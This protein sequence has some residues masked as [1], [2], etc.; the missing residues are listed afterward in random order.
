MKIFILCLLALIIIAAA[1]L[2]SRKIRVKIKTS[3]LVYIMKRYHVMVYSVLPGQMK[4]MELISSVYNETDI[5][6][7]RNEAYHIFMAVKKTAKIDGDIAEVGVYSGGSAKIISEAK[8]G[9][10][11]HLFD[12]FE[13]LPELSAH[14][15]KVMFHKNQLAASYES[16]KEY[17]KRY[18]N[19][20]MY[21]GMF[22]GTAEPLKSSKFSFVNLDAD[23]YQSTHDSLEFFYPRMNR[24]GIIISHDYPGSVGV[25]KAFDEFFQSKPEVVIEL[26]GN[27]CMVVK[28]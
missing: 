22:P 24:G 9:R 6:M 3:I 26:S 19:V 18:P 28:L 2:R 21:K 14:D 13:G 23:L 1:L 4:A 25:T 17:L 7:G 27:Q 8:G 5:L 11:L 16:V 15:D 20:K 10:A 12:T